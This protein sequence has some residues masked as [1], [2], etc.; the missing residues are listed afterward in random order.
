MPDLRLLTDMIDGKRDVVRESVRLND[1]LA[2]G[3]LPAALIEHVAHGQN[4]F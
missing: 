2:A 1:G 3:V 4:G